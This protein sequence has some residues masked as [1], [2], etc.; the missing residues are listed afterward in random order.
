MVPLNG[1]L[2]RVRSTATNTTGGPGHRL[3]R[4]QRRP[5]HGDREGREHQLGRRR[6]GRRRHRPGQGRLPDPPGDGRG[7]ARWNCAGPATAPARSTTSGP[8]PHWRRTVHRLRGPHAGRQLVLLSPAQA[9]RGKGRRDH[10][11]EIYYFETR[12]AAGLRRT[13]GR[14]RNRLPARIRLGRAAHRRLRG[15]AD[16][17]RRPGPLRLARPGH[18]GPGLRH[19][20]PQRHGGPRARSANGS[21]AT[22]RT[23]AGSARLGRP[24]HRPAAAVRRLAAMPVRG[25]VPGRMA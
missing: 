13:G 9:R 14:R 22:T 23:T 25:G 19:V 18:G 4:P 8:P 17:R 20:L 1:V 15:G 12:V 5:V 6:T 7:D 21:S 16:R 10:L 11:E 24:G 2:H 3:Q